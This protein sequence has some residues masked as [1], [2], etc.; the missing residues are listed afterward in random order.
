MIKFF[1]TDPTYSPNQHTHKSRT[2]AADEWSCAQNYKSRITKSRRSSLSAGRTLHKNDFEL[3][4]YLH[5]TQISRSSVTFKV[6]I[7]VKFSRS[8]FELDLE[9]CTWPWPL[10]GV[11]LWVF[12][13]HLVRSVHQHHD[14]N[15]HHQ[16]NLL[17]KWRLLT[18]ICKNLILVLTYRP[19]LTYWPL[20]VDHVVPALRLAPPPCSSWKMMTIDTHIH[21]LNLNTPID[22]LWST[23]WLWVVTETTP[24]ITIK[25]FSLKND[26]SW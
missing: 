3:S 2:K 19:L 23:A 1:R 16:S 24:S 26:T 15:R 10:S 5:T 11:Q 25:V 18:P 17:E 4:Q 6:K 20:V 7:E 9:T 13:T 21:E 12:P 14:Q 8:N 22:H